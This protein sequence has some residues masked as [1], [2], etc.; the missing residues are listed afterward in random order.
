MKIRKFR[1]SIPDWL[2]ELACDELGENNG[3]ANCQH[4][5]KQANVIIRANSL[6]INV[7]DLR[8]ELQKEDIQVEKIKG[9]PEALKLRERKNLF[10]TK[11]FQNGYFEIQDASSQLVAP[12]SKS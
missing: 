11:A 7:N 12:F 2:D 10:K 4:L 3:Q 9:F 6:K 1:E 5:N 8:K